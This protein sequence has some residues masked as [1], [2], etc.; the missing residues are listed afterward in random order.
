MTQQEHTFNSHDGAINPI[1]NFE[2]KFLFY[3]LLTSLCVYSGISVG[4]ADEYAHNTDCQ[5]VDI[6]DVKPGTYIFKVRP[7]LV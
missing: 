4:C 1:I 3:F 6:T 5:W 7:V 2:I